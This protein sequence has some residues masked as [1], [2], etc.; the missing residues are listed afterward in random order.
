M[1]KILNECQSLSS[2]ALKI[3]VDNMSFQFDN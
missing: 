2:T 3:D 1:Q